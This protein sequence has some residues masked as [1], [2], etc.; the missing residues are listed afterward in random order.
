MGETITPKKNPNL[1]HSLLSGVK[2]LE[3]KTPKNKKIK[4]AIRAQYTISPCD[5]RGHNDIVKKIMKNK[6]P[7]LLFD[8]SFVFLFKFI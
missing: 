8:E 1:S 3:F 5:I 2:N 7:K 6:I 4:E